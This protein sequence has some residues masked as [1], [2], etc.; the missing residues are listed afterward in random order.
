MITFEG[1]LPTDAQIITDLGSYS[2][3]TAGGTMNSIDVQFAD[4]SV[5]TLDY[6]IYVQAPMTQAV[7]D[8]LQKDLYNYASKVTDPT[9]TFTTSVQGY[10]TETELWDMIN[11]ADIEGTYLRSIT[12]GTELSMGQSYGPDGSTTTDLVV[13]KLF[14]HTAAQEAAVTQFV[15]DAINTLALNAVGKTTYDKVK[16]VYDYILHNAAYVNYSAP[17]PGI[18]KGDGSSTNPD[19]YYGVSV[20]SPYAITQYDRG[21]CQAYAALFA[22]FMDSLGI[23][24]YYATGHRAFNNNEGH[25]WNKVQIDGQWYNVDLTWDDPVT[26]VLSEPVVSGYERYK[27]FL[28]SDATFTQDHTFDA[29]LTA[30]PAALT[31]YPVVP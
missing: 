30:N 29:D 16:G 12:Q 22:K 9:V 2:T 18:V 8:Q 25:A 21:V 26:G 13:N 19:T 20:H 4:G 10:I 1:P 17:E 11:K 31:D 27:Y 6:V 5:K 23:N 15:N 3:A 24:T 28:K 7:R 14:H